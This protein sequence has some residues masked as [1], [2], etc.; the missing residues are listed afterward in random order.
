MPVTVAILLVVIIIYIKPTIIFGCIVM[1]H[2]SPKIHQKASQ[3]TLK[4]QNFLGHSPKMVSHKIHY[5]R[6]LA[7]PSRYVTGEDNMYTTS[8]VIVNDMQIEYSIPL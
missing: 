2:Y 7:I 8:Y 1:L 4:I 5:M 6:R 3:N